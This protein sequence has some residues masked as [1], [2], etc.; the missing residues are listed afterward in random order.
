MFVPSFVHN[1]EPA[2]VA[3]QE[4]LMVVFFENTG[5]T[6]QIPPTAVEPK[7]SAKLSTTLEAVSCIVI[8]KVVLLPLVNVIVLS[9]TLTP[10][11]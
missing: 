10:L 9:L 3:P 2:T 11:I 6:S 7:E 8:A 1:F 5:A 4:Y